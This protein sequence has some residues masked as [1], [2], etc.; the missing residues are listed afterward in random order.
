MSSRPWHT[1]H[2]NETTRQKWL[3][4]IASLCAAS[5]IPRLSGLPPHSILY[6]EEHLHR[7]QVFVYQVERA[8]EDIFNTIG[9]EANR[10]VRLIT[11]P[12]CRRWKNKVLASINSHRN[13]TAE[14]L[15]LPARLVSDNKQRKLSFEPTDLAETL[16]NPFL[17]AKRTSI[18]PRDREV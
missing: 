8:I 3:T 11:K 4:K 18:K 7:T 2:Q 13:C 6:F 9:T 14:K 15:Q 10:P 1:R 16:N 17:V 12:L 5:L